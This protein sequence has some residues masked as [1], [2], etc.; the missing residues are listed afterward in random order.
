VAPSI[1]RGRRKRLR[2]IYDDESDHPDRPIGA[3]ESAEWLPTDRDLLLGLEMYEATLCPGCKQPITEAWHS[4]AH[5]QYDG[6][7]IVCHA[8]TAAQGEEVSYTRTPVLFAAARAQMRSWPVF[9]LAETTTPP[10]KKTD[11]GG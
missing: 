1:F 8:C 7:P 11:D 9:N 5:G 4:Y 3:V 10:T 2:Y 6:G